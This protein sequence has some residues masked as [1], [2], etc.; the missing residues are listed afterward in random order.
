MLV[1]KIYLFSIFLNWRALTQWASWTLS[2]AT[3]LKMQKAK[4]SYTEHHTD[5]QCVS[6]VLTLGSD[7]VIRSVVALRNR[8]RQRRKR[9]IKVIL[10]SAGLWNCKG[11]LV[12]LTNAVLT[13]VTWQ[14]AGLKVCM[15]HHY[16]STS[17][18][19]SINAQVYSCSLFRALSSVTSSP[20]ILVKIKWILAGSKTKSLSPIHTYT[21]PKTKPEPPDQ[22]WTSRQN[23]NLQTKTEPLNRNWTFRP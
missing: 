3:L 22:N 8:S 1:I 16:Q 23:L 5:Y 7:V 9:N 10:N 2:A 14:P 21:K 18:L 12:N 17:P 11:T 15:W 19:L 6:C 20:V 4:L 13:T